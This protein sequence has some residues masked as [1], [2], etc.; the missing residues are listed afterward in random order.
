MTDVHVSRWICGYDRETDQLVVEYH[1]P[2]AWTLQ[3]L[4]E[5]F[6]V[7]EENPM[8]DSF[9]LDEEQERIF[10]RDLGTDLPAAGLAFFVEATARFR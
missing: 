7:P 1:L 8:Y 3:R 2:E 10:A 6:D 5:L 9:E 4:Q